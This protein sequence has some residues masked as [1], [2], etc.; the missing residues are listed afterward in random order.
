VAFLSKF[1]T[2]APAAVVDTLWLN[3]ALGGRVVLD[4][5]LDTVMSFVVEG[6]RISHVLAVR[7]PHKL[8]R[9]DQEAVLAR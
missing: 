6:S 8:G 4:G 2:L 1:S 5:E 9:L 3:G 7:N